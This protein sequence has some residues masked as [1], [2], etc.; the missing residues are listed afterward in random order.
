[1]DISNVDES[2]NDNTSLTN[3]REEEMQILNRA[4]GLLKHKSFTKRIS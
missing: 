1:M 3:I 2:Q 4:K